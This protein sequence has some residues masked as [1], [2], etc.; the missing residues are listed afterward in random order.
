MVSERSSLHLFFFVHV[1]DKIWVQEVGTRTNRAITISVALSPTKTHG[2]EKKDDGVGDPIKMLLE[3]ALAGQRNKIMDNF[4]QI[5]RW[6]PTREASSS[7]GH[8]TPFKVH[9]NLDIPL[10]EGLIDANVVD[11]WLNLL[12]GYF[13]STIFSIGKRSRL[14]SSRSFSMLKTGG[15]LTM[16]KGPWRNLQCLWWPLHGNP[17]GMPLKNNT[18]LL[19]ATRTSTRDGP[20]Y[21]KKGTRQY[22]I[23]PIFSIPY[24]PNWVSNTVRIIWCSNNVVVFIDTFKRKWISWTSP[25][26]ARL[27]DTLSRSSINLRRKVESLD[28]QTPHSRSRE[29]EA[30]THTKRDQF[31]MA[32]L[33]KTNPSR[34]TRREMRRRRR[35]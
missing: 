29:K 25:H 7:S 14:H 23:S 15:I 30:P 10:F 27:I 31:E 2:D 11:K 17:S 5:L 12:E 34:N 33:R 13:R 18:T 20:P 35:T 6:L 8:A 28:L 19:E 4:V 3:E 9:V 24:A 1:P 26:W 32:A 22:Q 21:I 16:S